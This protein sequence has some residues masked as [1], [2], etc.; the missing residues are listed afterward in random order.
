MNYSDFTEPQE[1]ALISITAT[2]AGLSFFCCWLVIFLIIIFK[3]YRFF[4]Q[5]L[6]LYIVIAAMLSSFAR[7]INLSIKLDSIDDEVA[8]YYCSITGFMDQYTSACFLL[9]IAILTIDIFLQTMFSLRTTKMEV[10]YVLFMFLFPLLY[11]W[12]PFYYEAYG[13]A[14]PWCWIKGDTNEQVMLQFGLFYIPCF[15]VYS[16]LFILLLVLLYVLYLRRYEYEAKMDVHIVANRAALRKEVK[17]MLIYPALIMVLNIV[18]L[19]T[20]IHDACTQSK[21]ELWVF[22]ALVSPL[23]GAVIAMV[24]AFDPE[25]RRRLTFSHICS[26]CLNFSGNA[27]RVSE[28]PAE[29]KV[30]ES[31]SSKTSYATT[32][33]D[34]EPLLYREN[35]NG[36]DSTM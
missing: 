12:I 27:G 32:L 11:C 14:G 2:V 7:T 35:Y 9:A 1:I 4:S 13:E 30:A 33:D 5:R 29:I 18:P 10:F 26:A 15:L 25:T 19:A 23:E 28:Y 3:K 17:I 21:F 8:E 20:R 34:K 36:Y 22:N 6:I 16:L 31:V 24:F